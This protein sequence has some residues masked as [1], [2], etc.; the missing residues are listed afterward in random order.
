[1]VGASLVRAGFD[2]RF[3]ARGAHGEAIRRDGLRVLDPTGARHV[4]VEVSLDG[5]QALDFEP[6]DIVLLAVKSQDTEAAIRAL[7]TAAHRAIPVVCLQNG[8]ENERVA[9]R[10]FDHVLAANVMVPASHTE[11]GIVVA[12]SAPVPGIVDVG[13]YPRGR[14]GVCEAVVSALRRG[15]FD[16]RVDDDILRWKRAKLLVNVGN[17]VRALCASEPSPT[18]L[19]ELVRAEARTA[20]AAAGVEYAGAEEYAARRGGIVTPQDVP[21]A[22][23]LGSSTVQSLA[24]GM[25]TAETDYLNGEIVLLGRLHDVPTPANAL[26]C[27]LMRDVIVGRR[28][29]GGVAEEEVLRRAV[30]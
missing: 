14:D 30:T 26:V 3:V 22:P 10:R 16:A 4:P 29:P 23:R 21:G 20:F 25:R 13:S 5:P 7:A 6:R 18:R 15:G 1:V 8:L 28:A 27:E 9:S 19:L 2:V 17:A 24:R 11:P 12:H